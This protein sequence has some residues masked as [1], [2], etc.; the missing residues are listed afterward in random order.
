M[1]SLTRVSMA[2]QEQRMQKGV[3]NVVSSSSGRLMP[4]TPT[5]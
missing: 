4:S 3:R 5:L 1:N 2:R